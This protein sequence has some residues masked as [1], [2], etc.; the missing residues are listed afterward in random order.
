MQ[1]GKKKKKKYTKTKPTAKLRVNK[2]I[3][4]KLKI[5][6]NLKPFCNVLCVKTMFNSSSLL[7]VKQFKVYICFF[8][9]YVRILAFNTISI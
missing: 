5:M 4:R 1:K 6:Q 3:R 7:F 9:I 8:P 2:T